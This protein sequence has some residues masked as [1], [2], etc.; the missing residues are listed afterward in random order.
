MGWVVTIDQPDE[1]ITGMTHSHY[2]FDDIDAAY[3][4]VIY[5]KET[6]RVTGRVAHYYEDS[7][8]VCAAC[9]D[10]AAGD[11]RWGLPHLRRPDSGHG[12][13]RLLPG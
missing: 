10:W 3:D 4:F 11:D 7:A 1:R 8:I 13:L 9:T 5:M 6:H 2:G 12:L